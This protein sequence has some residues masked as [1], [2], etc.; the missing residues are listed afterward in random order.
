MGKRDVSKIQNVVMTCNGSDCRKRGSKELGRCA[1]R[2]ARD[3]GARKSTMF[4]QTKC[5]GLCKQAPVVV[6]QNEVVVKADEKSV[7][8]AIQRHLGFA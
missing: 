1:R 8:R 3:L 6:V 2:I 4:L 7:T 5:A